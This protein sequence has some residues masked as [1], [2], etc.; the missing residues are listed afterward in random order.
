MGLLD[1]LRIGNQGVPE[2][3]GLDLLHM[4]LILLGLGLPRKSS[5]AEQFGVEAKHH[6]HIQR[7]CSRSLT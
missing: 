5:R 6:K 1:G 2:L 7:L 3:N 4:S